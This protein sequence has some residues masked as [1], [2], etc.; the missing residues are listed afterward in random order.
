MPCFLFYYKDKVIMFEKK[1]NISLATISKILLPILHAKKKYKYYPNLS[2]TDLDFQLSRPGLE[3]AMQICLESPSIIET[4]L[5][6][7]NKASNNPRTRSKSHGN[8]KRTLS[9]KRS[10]R[11]H[12]NSS[13][14]TISGTSP[15]LSTTTCSD[16]IEI[17]S[18]DASAMDIQLGTKPRSQSQSHGKLKRTLSPKRSPRIHDKENSSDTQISDTSPRLTNATCDDPLIDIIQDHTPTITLI[19][20]AT[21][22]TNTNSEQDNFQNEDKMELKSKVSGTLKHHSISKRGS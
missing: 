19:Y 18:R 14:D 9:T 2:E 7:S 3:Q 6:D 21:K 13:S 1:E 16:P 17:S 12:D 5:I 15:R 10:P 11:I 8:L 4:T 22:N 20:N